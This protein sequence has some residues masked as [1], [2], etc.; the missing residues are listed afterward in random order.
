MHRIQRVAARQLLGYGSWERAGYSSTGGCVKSSE[1]H[2]RA[3]RVIPSEGCLSNAKLKGVNT[4]SSR[5]AGAIDTS[6]AAVT[7]IV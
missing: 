5:T 2:Q 7:A 6:S 4:K 1:S 3:Q